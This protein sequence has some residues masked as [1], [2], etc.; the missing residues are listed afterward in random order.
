MEQIRPQQLAE[1]LSDDSRKKP[2]LLD[3]R[4]PATRRSAGETFAD[5]QWP[6]HSGQA[7]GLPGRLMV[8]LSGLACPV[9]YV[10]GVRMWWRKRSA[11]RMRPA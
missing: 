4:E 5:W 3:V 9:I 6:L 8:C 10:T 1:W 2:V 11:R 7:F